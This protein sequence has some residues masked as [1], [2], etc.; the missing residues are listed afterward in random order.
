MMKSEKL[1]RKK[2]GGYWL[3]KKDLEVTYMDKRSFMENKLD[4]E[5]IKELE[6]IA[7]ELDAEKLRLSNVSKSVCSHQW[8]NSGLTLQGKSLK[9]CLKCRHT[10]QTVC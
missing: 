10:E 3:T 1:L 6:V 9:V 4:I 8:I 5:K 2:D 7:K